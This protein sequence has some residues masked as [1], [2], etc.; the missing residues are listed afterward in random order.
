MCL[1]TVVT[2]CALSQTL[3]AQ[4]ISAPTSGSTFARTA[5]ITV[6]GQTGLAD[7]TYVV[8][9]VSTAGNPE[10]IMNTGGGISD[11]SKDFVITIPAPI[12]L[13]RVGP[14]EVRLRCKDQNGQDSVEV[15]DISIIL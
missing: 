2:T 6:S 14:A 11:S 1:I 15:V 10:V 3:Y 4:T 5:N 13:W 9:I 8:E 7:D 12:G